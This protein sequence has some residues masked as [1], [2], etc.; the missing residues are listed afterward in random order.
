MVRN[1]YVVRSDDIDAFK[2]GVRSRLARGW[3]LVGGMSVVSV[4]GKLTYHQALYME[5]DNSN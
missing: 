4:R 5:D 2:R 3:D 1:Y